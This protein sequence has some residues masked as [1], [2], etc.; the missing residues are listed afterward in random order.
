MNIIKS[1][2]SA[3]RCCVVLGS[4]GALAACAKV[5]DHNS[6]KTPEAA[7]DALVAALPGLQD[8]GCSFGTAGGF[9]R[10]L[11]G[12][13]E[14]GDDPEQQQGTWLGHVAEHVAL[15]A[16]RRLGLDRKLVE[17]GFNRHQLSAA[18]GTP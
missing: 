3:L 4:A 11:R 12:G 14:V 8:H 10:R 15:E 7:V 17:L 13:P 2:F 16:L 9:I 6:F 5:E 18:I 1:R